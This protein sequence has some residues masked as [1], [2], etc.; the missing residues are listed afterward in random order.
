MSTSTREVAHFIRKMQITAFALVS[1][2][3]HFE[4]FGFVWRFTRLWLYVW[5]TNLPS[6]ARLL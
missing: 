5:V 2:C 6:A 1:L 3:C 4:P